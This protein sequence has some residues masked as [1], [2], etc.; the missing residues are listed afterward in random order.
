MT[1]SEQTLNSHNKTSSVCRVVKCKLNKHELKFTIQN[2][3]LQ[4]NKEIDEQKTKIERVAKQNIRYSR[5][6]RS[7]KKSKGETEEEQDFDVR[8]LR[9]LNKGAVRQIGEVVHQFPDTSPAVQLY[10]N[11]ANL[12]LPAA[13]AV[14]SPASSRYRYTSNGHRKIIILISN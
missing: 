6:I 4:L 9:E 7:A 13:S 1:N 14:S 12:P 3:I 5:E 11:Q 10:F 2:K 8:D